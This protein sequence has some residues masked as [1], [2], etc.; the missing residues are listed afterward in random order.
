MFSVPILF[1]LL[2]CLVL[3][4]GILISLRCWG[5]VV[6]VLLVMVMVLLIPSSASAL[7]PLL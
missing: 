7:P 3:H 4:Q 5:V 1:L 6:L 2:L